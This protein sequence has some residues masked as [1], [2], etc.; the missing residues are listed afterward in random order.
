M[1][2]FRQLFK[3][4]PK[5]EES[6]FSGPSKSGIAGR[7]PEI[8]EDITI[9]SVKKRRVKKKADAHPITV[10]YASHVGRIRKRNEDSVLVV[11][12]MTLG[13]SDLSPFGIFAVADG[14]GGHSQGQEASQ[15]AV[16]II[17]HDVMSQ[18]FLPFLQIDSTESDK[19]IQDIMVSSTHISNWKV[20]AINP[21][22]KT[23]LTAA[24]A[25]GDQLYVVHV[26]DSRAYLFRDEKSPAELLTL[27]HS[28]IQKL[29][30]TKQITP[31]E[32]AVHPQ[33]NVLYRA[34]GQGDELEVDTFSCQLPRPSWLLLCS[35]G[36]WRVVSPERIQAVIVSAASPQQAC[37]ELVDSA[38]IAGGPDNISLIMVRFE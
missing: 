6:D 25:L 7:L 12:S 5:P 2:F 11:T 18:I 10:G 26:G 21:E 15:F 17:A 9:V 13:D 19:P 23:T 36:L 22:A 38:L 37:D 32:A 3:K 1:E 16:R 4:Q 29:Q 34:I 31:E 35:D 30:D 33:R 8:D 27:D 20:N 14:M 24:L 28:V